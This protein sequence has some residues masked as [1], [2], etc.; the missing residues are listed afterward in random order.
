VPV[1]ATHVTLV[2]PPDKVFV[3]VGLFPTHMEM[4]DPT[5]IALKLANVTG[6][7]TVALPHGFDAIN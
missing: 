1:D 5:F 3:N 4:F 7:F 2:A 6:K